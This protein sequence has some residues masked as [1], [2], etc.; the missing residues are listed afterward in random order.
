MLEGEPQSFHSLNNSEISFPIRQLCEYWQPCP[1]SS[2]EINLFPAVLAF[3]GKSDSSAFTNGRSHQ[4][5]V[6][7]KSKTIYHIEREKQFSR[8]C[9][10]FLFFSFLS[11]S[12]SPQSVAGQE[13]YPLGKHS[14]RWCG[15][16]EMC[17]LCHQT[18]PR[19]NSN[20]KNVE[21]LWDF[22]SLSVK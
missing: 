22:V 3:L 20:S 7:Y 12:F 17:R 2:L 18:D 1:S 16:E 21:F 5:N 6:N 9:N 15:I 10:L 11:T 4:Q 19:P 13:H 8:Q 14:P